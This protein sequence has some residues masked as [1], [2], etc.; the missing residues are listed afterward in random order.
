MRLKAFLS[1]ILLSILV[2]AGCSGEPSNTEVANVAVEQSP[3]P[4]PQYA[5]AATAMAEGTRLFDENDLEGSIA[6]FEAA[7]NMQSDLAE[8]YFKLG[9]AYAL[10]E[11]QQLQSGT[12]PPD[13]GKK[14]RSERYFEKAVEAYKKIVKAE[15]E[16]DAALFNLGR[17]YGKILKD[18]EAEKELQKAVKLRPNDSEYQMELGATLIR[19]A[20]YN[21]AVKALKKAIEVEPSSERLAELLEEAEAGVKRVNFQMP[22]KDGNI[23]KDSNSRRT[24][25]GDGDDTDP[26]TP[27][28]ASNTR[29]PAANTRPPSPAA[30]RPASTS[31]PPA[32]P[33]PQN[34][35]RPRTVDKRGNP[36][37]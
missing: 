3:S 2:F 9:V 25:G 17:S 22:K 29:P 28:S 30:N 11:R 31:R 4:T 34:P 14:P 18:E 35:T 8:G 23:A 37:N 15:P 7:V 16:N 5:D 10:L 1:V 36:S 26:A 24:D 27:P 13:N 20:K 21:E 33:A 6:A 32:P 12:A 19:L